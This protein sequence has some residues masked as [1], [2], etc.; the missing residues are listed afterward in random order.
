MKKL[1]IVGG[2]TAGW[3]AALF[4]NN[5][6]KNFDVTVIESSSIG[7][8]GAG[9]GSTPHLI[10]FFDRL[11]IP[12][13]DLIKHAGATIKNG[14]KFTNWNN[15][16]KHYYHG[17]TDNSILN[18]P[19]MNAASIDIPVLALLTIAKGDHLDDVT[20]TSLLS[21]AN[22]V[23]FT[24]QD[25]I[26]PSVNRICDFNI[27]GN[28]SIH[29]NARKLASY[30]KHL[31]I[32][33]GVNHIDAT[34]TDFDINPNGKVEGVQLI[35]TVDSSK[36]IKECDFVIDCSGFKRLL[37]DKI[38]KSPWKSYA[39]KLPVNRALPFFIDYKPDED[40]PPYTESIAMKYGWVWKIPVEGRYGC[41]YVF[42]SSLI[43]DQQAKQEVEDMLGV[44]I[45]FPTSFNFS[46]G[47]FEKPWNKNSLALGL[48]SGF[49]EPLEATSIWSTITALEDF[50][51]HIDGFLHE[52]DLSIEIFNQKFC[53][54]QD[55]IFNFVFLHYITKRS[56]TE[57]WNKFKNT[58]K[59]SKPVK[60]YLN[61]SDKWI[62]W[63]NNFKFGTYFIDESY[64]Q[65]GFG[66]GHFSQSTAQN[67]FK[68]LDSDLVTLDL[69]Y[70]QFRQNL[71]ISNFENHKEF[72]KYLCQ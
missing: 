54:M 64:L 25:Q 34:V 35:N 66:L 31:A 42:D 23:K 4:I 20:L 60:D 48:S 11:G 63:K 22:K 7:I 18:H 14:I 2:G 46:A 56:D 69:R 21:E 10:N 30:L 57:F 27:H 15:D 17:F 59:Y 52:N 70:N 44:G 43:S 8:L 39:D 67:I 9:E 49:I 61:Y 26:D 3:L 50:A 32:A 36:S 29:F 19:D 40:I 33:R 51:E 12:V 55:D 65:V 53:E 72:L 13:S 41:G 6:F 47:Y 58:N 28:Y 71:N 62:A 5:K 1:L 38:Y 68:S 37:V 16:N 24:K 45:N